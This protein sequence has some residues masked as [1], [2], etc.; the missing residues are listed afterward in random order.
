MSPLTTTVRH[1]LWREATRVVPDG[2]SLYDMP[3]ILLLGEDNPQSSKLEHALWP[4]PSTGKTGCAGKNLQS[5]I[6]A[7]S[8]VHYYALWRTNLCNPT[9]DVKQ[10]TDR[11][12][13]L[14]SAYNP[15]RTIVLLGR[16]VA[17][18]AETEVDLHIK[19]WTWHPVFRTWE[20][21]DLGT[22]EAV[23]KL[24]AL[25]HPSGLTRDWNEPANFVRAQHLLAEV[26]PEVPWGELG[27]IPVPE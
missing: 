27:R 2:A 22:M 25:P 19:P 8:H 18:V 10:A 13:E 12:E 1:Q 7:I 17:K 14:I 20:H 9:W 26:A 15:W 24:V 11:M 21:D 4:V 5:K 16:K 23:I 6:L 3:R